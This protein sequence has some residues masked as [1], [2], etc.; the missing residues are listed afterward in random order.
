MRRPS[1]KFLGRRK[2]PPFV[3]PVSLKTITGIENKTFLEYNALQLF[4][5][6]V[7]LFYCRLRC[8]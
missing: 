6:I 2:M 7:I 4:V 1:V 5:F 3:R 8:L